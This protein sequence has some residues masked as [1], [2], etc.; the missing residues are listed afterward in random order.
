MPSFEYKALNS[1]G[2]EM[3]G[4]I[5]ANNQNQALKQLQQKSLYPLTI[6]KINNAIGG[7]SNPKGQKFKLNFFKKT[8]TTTM[9]AD[10]SRQF[11]TLIE[12]GIPYN[13][14]LEILSQ[15]LKGE[16]MLQILSEINLKVVEGSSLSKAMSTY[17]EVFPK[18]YLT[19]VTAGEKTGNLGQN[20]IQQAEFLENQSELKS[21]IQSALIYP[22]IMSF[23]GISIVIFMIQVIL[24]KIVPI[25]G[26][27][28]HAL[29]L[30]TRIMIWL[31]DIISNYT[32]FLLF[33]LLAI[34]FLINYTIKSK[35][36][37]V[38][39]D[40]IILKLPLVST[41]M[42]KV[43]LLRFTMS[44]S[45]LLQSGIAVKEALSIATDST[46]N[47]VFASAIKEVEVL[48]VN[49][50]YSFSQ[51]L[52]KIKLFD[53]NFVQV[54]K[55]GEESGQLGKMIKKLS[56][57]LKRDTN[58]SIQKFVSL[59]EPIIIVIMALMVG[60]IVLAILLPI[61]EMNQLIQ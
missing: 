19:S 8:V 4:K 39:I 46:G 43:Y 25:F 21:K 51:A 40:K 3:S 45:S 32:Y 41:L 28:E 30:P 36:G 24:P 7:E 29:P 52:Q 54:V 56:E 6:K 34:L 2:Q 1:R 47:S 55:V 14:S 10:F 27:F 18:Y 53:A 35:K 48:A 22:G 38:Y 26:F 31:S 20:L 59:L 37:R 60:M 5:N 44:F 16:L 61:F 23:L 57:N 12:T 11:G 42:R 15:S 17:P 9:L 49:K 33:G 13:R 58:T 50:G